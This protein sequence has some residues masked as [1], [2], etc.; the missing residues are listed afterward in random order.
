MRFRTICEWIAGMAFSLT[1]LACSEVRMSAGPAVGPAVGP[2]RIDSVNPRYFSDG[3]GKV[4]F[5]SVPIH[6]GIFRCCFG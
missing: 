4:V 3:A 1:V 5:S 6:G 2:L